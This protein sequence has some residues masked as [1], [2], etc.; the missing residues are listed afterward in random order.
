[1]KTEQQIKDKIDDYESSIQIALKYEAY[2]LAN[3]A[4]DKKEALEWV[5]EE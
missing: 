4:Q 2:Y 1:M 3:T 5:L